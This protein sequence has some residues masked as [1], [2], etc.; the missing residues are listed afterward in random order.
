[1]IVAVVAIS[2]LIGFVVAAGV[3]GSQAQRLGR[4]RREPVWRLAEAASFV[5]EQLPFAISAELSAAE[6]E[7][8]LRAH[9]NQ[10]QFG[11]RPANGLVEGVRVGGGSTDRDLTG[12][13]PDGPRA[14]GDARGLSGGGVSS[15]SG[16]GVRG[17]SDGDHSDPASVT[18]DRS[19]AAD[20]YRDV[21]REGLEVSL[22]EVHAVAAAHLE[23]L[24]VIGALAPVPVS[25]RAGGRL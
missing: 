8:L 4:Q 1:M 25:V 6:L 7:A 22:E 18:E 20:L 10:L 13:V 24:R 21:R 5:A 2:L 23:Y 12:E 11:S 15:V 3:L 16:G 9:L 14:D 19:S 17:L